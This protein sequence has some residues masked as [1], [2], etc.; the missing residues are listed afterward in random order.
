MHNQLFRSPRGGHVR[1]VA[2]A[3]LGAAATIFL[4]TPSAFAQD[5]G[6]SRNQARQSA[7]QMR[8]LGEPMDRCSAGAGIDDGFVIDVFGPTPLQVG[9]RIVALNGADMSS[10]SDEQLVAALRRTAPDAQVQAVVRRGAEVVSVEIPCANS[11]AQIEPYLT[12]LDHAARGRFGDCVEALNASG[13][14]DYF[15]L[16]LKLQCASFASRPE[17]Y[18]VGGITYQLLVKAVQAAHAVPGRRAATIAQLRASEGAISSARGAGTFRDLVNRTRAWPGDE[19]AW[20]RSEPDWA[21]FRR[22]GE[23]ALRQRL[24]DPESARIQW[25]HGFLLGSWGPPFAS[26]IEGLDMRSYQR[27]QQDGRLY[28]FDRVCGRYQSAGSGS[29][30][31]AGCCARVRCSDGAVQQFRASASPTTARF[32]R[33]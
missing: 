26:R 24:I 30:H 21:L 20:D 15:T 3:A 22:N 2:L 1:I 27:T 6:D 17:R 7:Q 14:T 4:L 12:A 5:R 33:L 19:R 31:R 8:A 28:R 25:T 23:A 9:D 11:R 32:L 13:L 10:A 18:D 16:A 29:V